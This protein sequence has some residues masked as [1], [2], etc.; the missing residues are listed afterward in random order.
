MNKK[1][2]L[3]ITFFMLMALA[4]IGCKKTNDG[5]TSAVPTIEPPGKSF[6]VSATG[7]D[8][9][10]GL[11]AGAAFKNINTGIKAAAAGDT[12][13]VMNGTYTSPVTITTEGTATRSFT[14]K[15][16]PGHTPKI[17]ISGEI[18]NALSINVSYVVVDGLELQG[19]NANLTYTDALAAYNVALAGGTPMGK[20]N[21]NAIN[22]GGPGTTS[23]FPHH[24]TIRNCK[25]HDF[26]GGGLSSIQADYTTFEN[27]TV[28]NN[29]WY[30]M[31]GGSGISI[32][33]PS[34]SD[35]G[36]T[37][38]YKNFIRNNICYG[39]KTTIPWIGIVPQR[40]SDGNGIII[41]VNQTGYS[42][43][44]AG[45]AGR[46]LVENNISFNNGGSGIHAY[47]ADHVDIV[48]NTAYGNGTVVGY[49]DI[50]AGSC[51]DVKIANNI[52]YSRPAASGGKCNAAPSAGTFV[53]YDYNIY[54]NGVVAVQGVHDKI[55]DPQFINLNIDGTVANFSLTGAS[56]AID[57]GTKIIYS[58]K[59]IKGMPRPLGGAVDIG[60]Y[61]VK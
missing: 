12:V 41:D 10:N 26:P 39:N 55:V 29:A 6:Y 15:S 48:N 60:A 38:T 18:W 8:A 17:Y 33:T 3:A 11:S 14:L 57:A 36:N 58:A 16:Y 22:I 52:M 53:T 50:Y 56:P 46:T 35:A 27:N 47:K 5:T 23:K 25:V 43:T 34:N 28:Y 9:N 51:T 45:Y 13:F 32:L 7:S 24:I 40:L 44:G 37:A 49:A 42:G 1:F 31:Y 4:I 21:T 59:D 30:M 54:F 19:D 61:E 20:Y 2:S